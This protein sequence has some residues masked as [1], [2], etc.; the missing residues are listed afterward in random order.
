MIL[1]LRQNGFGNWIAYFEG[2]PTI[3]DVIEY[4]RAEGHELEI[5]YGN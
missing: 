4:F 1:I 2:N 5:K 3:G